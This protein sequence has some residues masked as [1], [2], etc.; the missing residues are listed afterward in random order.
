M[1][2]SR[3]SHAGNED[4][5]FRLDGSTL[6]YIPDGLAEPRTFVLLVEVRG[7]PRAPRSAV[8]ALVV[9]VTPRS[10]TV[11]P[12]TT[13]RRMVSGA[14]RPAA[15]CRGTAPSLPHPRICRHHGRSRWW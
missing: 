11:P 15:P 6:S 14:L 4:G 8:V 1:V 7:G 10:T 3:P 2:L 5:R 12:S 13:A 9:H